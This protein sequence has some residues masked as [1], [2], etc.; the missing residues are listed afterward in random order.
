MVNEV[1]P[2]QIVLLGVFFSGLV[3]AL[4]GWGRN[5]EPVD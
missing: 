3:I 1:A 2:G 5:T 4:N